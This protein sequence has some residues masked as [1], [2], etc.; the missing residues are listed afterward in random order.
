MIES[1][2]ELSAMVQELWDHD[3]NRLLPGKDYRISLQVCNPAGGNRSNS[4]RFYW[5]LSPS[6]LCRAKPTARPSPTT[7]TTTER[8][9]LCL[10]SSMRTFSRR[11]PFW[12]SAHRRVFDTCLPSRGFSSAHNLLMKNSHSLREP[13]SGRGHWM[14]LTYKAAHAVSWL[15]NRCQF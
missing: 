4:L 14:T 5:F 10:R 13:G 9:L 3:V 2:R 6:P 1:D 15:C 11:R 8:G 7:T 12:V